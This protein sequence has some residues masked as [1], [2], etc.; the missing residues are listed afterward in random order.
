MSDNNCFLINSRKEVTI[1]SWVCDKE[2]N[3]DFNNGKYN[4]LASQ[5]ADPDWILHLS[6]KIWIDW[7]EF[8]PCYMQALRN[9]DIKELEIKVNY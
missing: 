1:G 9:A 4:I 5:L 2:G 7:N 3:M 8:I 6:G